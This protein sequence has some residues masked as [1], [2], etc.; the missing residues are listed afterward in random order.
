MVIPHLFNSTVI[1]MATEFN[2]NL[3]Y[4]AFLPCILLLVSLYLCVIANIEFGKEHKKHND[5]I[6][7]DASMTMTRHGAIINL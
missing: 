7:D 6:D 1:T 5:K 4:L 3:A 2:E